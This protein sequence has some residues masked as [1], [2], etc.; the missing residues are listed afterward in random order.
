MEI[1][2]ICDFVKKNLG[3]D[4]GLSYAICTVVMLMLYRSCRSENKRKVAMVVTTIATMILT[5]SL[6][7]CEPGLPSVPPHPL[8]CP[9]TSYIRYIREKSTFQDAGLPQ[10]RLLDS[11]LSRVHSYG[12]QEP[13]ARS[14][15]GPPPGA[16]ALVAL[17]VISAMPLASTLV[18]A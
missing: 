1:W 3:A 4:I 18:I 12:R 14:T 7:R 17:T 5:K 16:S 13:S 2:N 6:C 9:L 10:R 11:R 8:S 15:Y